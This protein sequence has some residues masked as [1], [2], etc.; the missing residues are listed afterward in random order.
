[1]HDDPKFDFD[2]GPVEG[3]RYFIRLQ[4]RGA[5]HY[6][7]LRHKTPCRGAKAQ[8]KDLTRIDC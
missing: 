1:M 2:G 8:K 5:R 4:A 3:V 7:A 6:G